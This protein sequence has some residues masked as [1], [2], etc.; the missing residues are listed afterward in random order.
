MNNVSVDTVL[1]QMRALSESAKGPSS[2]AE[3]NAGQGADFSALLQDS[4]KQVN[5]VQAD[6]TELKTA[7]EA[8]ATNVSL[9]EVMVAVQKASVSFE[10]ITQVR[11]KL[12]TAYQEVMNMQV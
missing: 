5:S 9:P 6:A 2:T 7:F 1:A 12:L 8:G 3:V 11:N 4:L 10:A